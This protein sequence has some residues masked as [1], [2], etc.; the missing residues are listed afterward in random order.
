MLIL[1]YPRPIHRFWICSAYLA[2][3]TPDRTPL[4]PP[5]HSHPQS[6]RAETECRRV[7]SHQQAGIDSAMDTQSEPGGPMPLTAIESPGP[8]S[9]DEFPM[10]RQAKRSRLLPPV[11][12]FGSWSDSEGLGVPISPVSRGPHKDLVSDATTDQMDL[13]EPPA[14]AESVTTAPPRVEGISGTERSQITGAISRANPKASFGRQ[15]QGKVGG[16]CGW[17]DLQRLDVL[18][19]EIKKYPK[20]LDEYH[21]LVQKVREENGDTQD[22][23]QY[24]YL[25][26]VGGSD[27][28]AQTMSASKARRLQ[29]SQSKDRVIARDSQQLDRIEEGDPDRMEHGPLT[30]QTLRHNNSE[31]RHHAIRQ[32][33]GQSPTDE[34]PMSRLLLSSGGGTATSRFSGSDTQ[35]PLISPPISV[36]S[37]QAAVTEQRQS[38]VIPDDETPAPESRTQRRASA[39]TPTHTLVPNEKSTICPECDKRFTMPSKLK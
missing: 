32:Y 18:H 31:S 22:W 6:C 25:C 26:P 35:G 33:V 2:L 8:A 13:D 34:S 20:I 21:S 24:R 3:C 38:I 11:P 17:Q 19:E 15:D 16:R 39:S 12:R 23:P 4:H 7:Y 5:P 29:R 27:I 10:P 28:S 9:T 1:K 14:T 37:P 30:C 36:A